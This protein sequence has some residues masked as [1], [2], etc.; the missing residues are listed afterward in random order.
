MDINYLD[1]F[2]DYDINYDWLEEPII[3]RIPKWYLRDMQNS[4]EG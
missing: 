3:D 1:Y 2:D 4:I